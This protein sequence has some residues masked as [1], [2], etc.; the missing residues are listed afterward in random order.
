MSTKMPNL[1]DASLITLSHEVTR[2]FHEASL[3]LD[4]PVLPMVKATGILS[5]DLLWLRLNQHNAGYESVQNDYAFGS[6]A[7]VLKFFH[8]LDSVGE[9]YFLELSS[10]RQ[11]ATLLS[12]VKSYRCNVTYGGKPGSVSPYVYSAILFFLSGDQASAQLALKKGLLEYS[13]P[14]PM[15]LWQEI[16]LNEFVERAKRLTNFFV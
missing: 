6:S 2:V 16:R 10:R 1:F 7:S 5:T 15:L 12:D 4:G 9:S 3:F 11:I 14:T 8:D 13:L